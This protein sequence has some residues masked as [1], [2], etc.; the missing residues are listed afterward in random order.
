MP[1]AGSI[2][3]P[4]PGVQQGV[5]LTAFPDLWRREGVAKAE[6]AE[7]ARVPGSSPRAPAQHCPHPGDPGLSVPFCVGSWRVSVLS[8][9]TVGA[10]CGGPR[11]PSAVPQHQHSPA[12]WQMGLRPH[13]SQAGQSGETLLSRPGPHG[14][15]T[16]SCCLY[17]VLE[18]LSR[19]LLGPEVRL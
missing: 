1:W 19:G 11:G 3:A 10:R 6:K 13:A 15:P 17:G 5:G 2:I 18:G 14:A 9:A 16:A 4:G 7:G 8:P 12:W